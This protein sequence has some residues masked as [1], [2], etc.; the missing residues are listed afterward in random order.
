MDFKPRFHLLFC[1]IYL[2]E[3]VHA[4]WKYS[5]SVTVKKMSRAHQIEHE[6][7]LR[8]Y[9]QQTEQTA[10]LSV[11]MP[12]VNNVS[13][14]QSNAKLCTK[15]FSINYVD[16]VDNLVPQAPEVFFLKKKEEAKPF[17]KCMAHL[18]LVRVYKLDVTL[19]ERE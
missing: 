7:D 11:P 3:L 8:F 12:M 6:I 18:S 19:V 9:K 14:W 16:R 13:C 1:K 4:S 10:S 2:E 17:T 15:S 5:S